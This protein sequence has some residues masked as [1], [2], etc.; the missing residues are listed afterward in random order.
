MMR[1]RTKKTIYPMPAVHTAYCPH[2]RVVT[3]LRVSIMPGIV[4]APDGEEQLV[5]SKTY[6]CQACGLFVR[7][8]E[9]AQPVSDYTFLFDHPD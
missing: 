3:N 4:T 9:D 6:H 2:C 5:T 8:E 7:S 1:A